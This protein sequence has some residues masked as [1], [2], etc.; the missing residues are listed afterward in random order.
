[1]MLLEA[2]KVPASAPPP[3]QAPRSQV[4][5]QQHEQAEAK[6]RVLFVLQVVPDVSA[7]ETIA[8]HG[9]A[10]KADAAKAAA[11]PAKTAPAAE[12]QPGGA[13]ANPPNPAPVGKAV[14]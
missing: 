14:Q 12:S 11:A 9:P 7:P 6:R 13:R 5:A 1:M 8:K 3:G 4:L 2:M 10:A